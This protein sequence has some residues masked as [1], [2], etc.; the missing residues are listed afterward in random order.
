MRLGLNRKL[1]ARTLVTSF[2]SIMPMNACSD[3]G[4]D[5]SVP[6]GQF[7]EEG[8]V[9]EN[10]AEERHEVSNEQNNEVLEGSEMD[11]NEVKISWSGGGDQT[12]EIEEVQDDSIDDIDDTL[13][14][15]PLQNINDGIIE[16]NSVSE[17]D[18]IDDSSNTE[19]SSDSSSDNG[20]EIEMLGESFIESEGGSEVKITGVHTQGASEVRYYGSD[21]V[22]YK[23][24][25]KIEGD[26]F[27]IVYSPG[28]GYISG[29]FDNLTG[30]L[31]GIGCAFNADQ[32]FTHSMILDI[33]VDKSTISSDA[34]IDEAVNESI[35][36]SWT[37][38]EANSTDQ[39]EDLEI[40]MNA[41][42]SSCE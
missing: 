6:S 4:V 7:G 25:L 9:A 30:V 22:G 23:L 3:S 18:F 1:L 38:S 21:E 15:G 17:I 37:L 27:E 26:S 42:D 35:D 11:E 10:A 36:Q 13:T 39:F 2:L 29:S 33:G 19:V 8:E 32:F 12:N 31:S 14:F 24:Y 40:R 5:K 16:D 20:S 41:G 28:S 34:P